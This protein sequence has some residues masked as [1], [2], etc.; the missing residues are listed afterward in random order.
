MMTL[1][2]NRSTMHTWGLMLSVIP[3][4]QNAVFRCFELSQ[5]RR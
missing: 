4:G 5:A 3:S 1:N 2:K